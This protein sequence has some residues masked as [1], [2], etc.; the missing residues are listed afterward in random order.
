MPLLL[1]FGQ[2]QSHCWQHLAQMLHLLLR[3]VI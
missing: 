3:V 2:Q 1:L